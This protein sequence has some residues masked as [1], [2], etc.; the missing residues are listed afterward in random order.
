MTGQDQRPSRARFG[1]LERLE[2]KKQR[3]RTANV[4]Q[5]CGIRQRGLRL[6]NAKFNWKQPV[7]CCVIEVELFLRSSRRSTLSNIGLLGAFL[8]DTGFS[9][10]TR[11]CKAPDPFQ[12]LLARSCLVRCFPEVRGGI[13]AL[14][15]FSG[16]ANEASPKDGPW[17]HTLTSSPCILLS[18]VAVRECSCW[19]KRWSY[20]CETA[21]ASSNRLSI[22]ARA[23]CSPVQDLRPSWLSWHKRPQ[24]PK[25]GGN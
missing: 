15:L 25:N 17:R 7:L 2:D 12:G 5:N 6:D 9:N 10:R 14:E 16:P 4:Q 8:S 23:P 21:S 20:L 24:V 18:A 13:A 22:L 11:H 3:A 19:H 1:E